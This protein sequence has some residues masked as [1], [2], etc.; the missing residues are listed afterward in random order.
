MAE[1][2]TQPCRTPGARYSITIEPQAV[3]LQV[4]LPAWALDVDAAVGL[5]ALLH[6][7][8]EGVL[9]SYWPPFAATPDEA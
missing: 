1:Q 9:A 7:A 2:I 5:E 8:V 4:E 6:E 3:R